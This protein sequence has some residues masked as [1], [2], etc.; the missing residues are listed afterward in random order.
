MTRRSG[1]TGP[2]KKPFA[3]V[4]SRNATGSCRIYIRPS[5]NYLARVCPSSARSSWSSPMPP[6]TLHPMDID[7][8]NEF[9]LGPDLLVAP[10]PFPEEPDAYGLK[11]PPGVWYDYWTGEKIQPA[12]TEKNDER[13]EPANS[14]K[15]RH[16]SCLCARRNHSAVA[17][18][19]AKH[20][21]KTTGVAHTTSLS[22][23]RLP[24]IALYG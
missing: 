7:A 23:K 24:R 12:T 16:T 2:N 3:A 1:Y 19:H 21:R 6:T 10:P 4:I 17:T 8:G 9:L 18:A 14:T 20:G 5:K 15:T 11:L 22:G 13:R